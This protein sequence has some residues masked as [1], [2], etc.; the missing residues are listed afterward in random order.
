MGD[1]MR[2]RSGCLTCF[3]LLLAAALAGVSQTGPPIGGAG[4][5]TAYDHYSIVGV[6]LDQ[7]NKPATGAY[8]YLVDPET[9][10]RSQASTN[11]IGQFSFELTASTY[12][13]QAAKGNL[14]SSVVDV[15]V[16]RGAPRPFV[17]LVVK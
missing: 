4:P 10:F 7:G 11:S 3:L 13:L 2:M 6:V 5:P 1:T 14:R 15:T 8:V 16:G 12:R 17:Q 9:N